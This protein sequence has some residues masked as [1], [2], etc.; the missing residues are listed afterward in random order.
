MLPVGGGGDVGDADEGAEEVD[1][2]EVW[3]DVAAFDGAFDE[4]ADGVPDL[5]VGGF[6][7][8]MGIGERF[9]EGGGAAHV[10]DVARLYKLAPE[11]HVA[12]AKYHAVAE[13]GV[14]LRDIAESIGRGLKVPVVSLR[15]V[16]ARGHCGWWGV[17]VGADLGASS[18]ITREK[19]GWEPTGPGLIADLAGMDYSGVGNGGN[20]KMGIAEF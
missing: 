10:D 4:G 14:R 6:E 5:G 11:K 20:Q 2:V 3:A 1:G 15:A 17:F 8:I 19:L 16:D 9:A 12:G 18:R 13:E 7:E